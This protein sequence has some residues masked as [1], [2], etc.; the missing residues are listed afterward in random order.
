MVFFAIKYD[1]ERCPRSRCLDCFPTF[2]HCGQYTTKNYIAAEAA[3]R[4]K[5]AM[6]IMKAKP[7]A[8]FT[9]STKYGSI[10]LFFFAGGIML[11]RI[12]QQNTPL[13]GVFCAS[14]MFERLWV[15]LDKCARQRTEVSGSRLNAIGLLELDE[16]RFGRRAKQSRFFAL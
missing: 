11:P 1:R 5:R 9:N 6:A 16:C 12:A 3:L 2:Y 10:F 15:V 8:N 7:V 4:A 13:C 14:R